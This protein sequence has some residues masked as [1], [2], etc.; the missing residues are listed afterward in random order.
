M[1]H[2]V[3]YIPGPYD[4]VP[5]DEGAAL[6]VGWLHQHRN[7]KV[8]LLPHMARSKRCVRKASRL[9]MSRVF[10]DQREA[11]PNLAGQ[12]MLIGS[13]WCPVA[14]FGCVVSRCVF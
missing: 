14:R 5:P 9:C 13:D 3:G 10:R 7:P 11:A 2:K 8:V 4:G 1:V 6:E 12:F